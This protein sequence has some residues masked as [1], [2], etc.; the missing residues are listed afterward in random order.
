MSS[1]IRWSPRSW[2]P[3]TA[4]GSERPK[5]RLAA[6][7][8]GGGVTEAVGIDLIVEVENGAWPQGL[9]VEEKVRQATY[10]LWAELELPVPAESEIS[11]L[12]TDDQRIRSLNA[13]WRGIDKPTNVL[14]FPSPEMPGSGFP[15]MLG[16]IVLAAETVLREAALEKRPLE[17]HVSHLIVHGLLHL[18]GYDHE[19]DEEAEEMER[20]EAEILFRLGIPDPYDRSL[21]D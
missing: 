15:R 5:D 9:D 2:P 20:I 8:E 14:S 17:H 18:L 7:P 16:D 4:S 10:A 12:F 13:A 19:S 6:G 11:F 1:V 3:M 21:T